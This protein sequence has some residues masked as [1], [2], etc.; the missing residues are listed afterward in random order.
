VAGRVKLLVFAAVLLV[1]VGCDHVTKHVARDVLAD[2]APLSLAAGAVRFELAYNPGGFLSLGV[3]LPAQLRG[4]FFVAFVPLALLLVCALFLRSG[5]FAG[6]S[7]VGLGL[8]V[9]GGVANW[10]DRLA[11]AGAVTDFVSLGVGPLRTGIF[12]LADVWVL[13]GAL[14]LSLALR[15]VGP[16]SE[17]AGPAR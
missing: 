12:N 13:A 16:A 3:G 5:V 17:G 4:V 8:V 15:A 1:A 9:G 7:V 10:L 6:R 11:H 14:V 2:A